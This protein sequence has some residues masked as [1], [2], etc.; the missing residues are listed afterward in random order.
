MKAEDD[1]V[2]KSP[3]IF[4]LDILQTP[5]LHL[6]FLFF[7]NNYWATLPGTVLDAGNIT[8]STGFAYIHNRRKYSI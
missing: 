2:E 7:Y 4:Y 3:G 6:F 1:W 8:M 5:S